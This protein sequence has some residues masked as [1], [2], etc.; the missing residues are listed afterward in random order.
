LCGARELEIVPA[1]RAKESRVE[2]ELRALES[3]AGLVI[4]L[5]AVWRYYS[6]QMARRTSLT[7]Q[8][9]VSTLGGQRALRSKVDSLDTLR[10]RLERGLPYES[11]TALTSTY[12]LDPRRLAAVLGIPPRTLAR[13]KNQ[14]RLR[15]DESDRL[16]RVARIV[17]LAGVTLG[18]KDKAARWLKRPNRALG[19]E[20]PLHRLKTELGARQ[21]EDVLG[22][23][24]H[25]VYS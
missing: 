20:A 15:P 23:I 10:L 8:C 7:A 21:V 17:A 2:C 18:G 6:C 9:L 5:F 3:G 11:L 24:S 25:G 1:A 12:N 4:A 14:R 13:R 19:N 16:F 22:R